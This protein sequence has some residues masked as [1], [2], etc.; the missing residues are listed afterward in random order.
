MAVTSRLFNAYLRRF[1]NCQDNRFRVMRG[2]PEKE[3]QWERFSTF[4]GAG[5]SFKLAKLPSSRWLRAYLWVRISQ[6]VWTKASDVEQTRP[7]SQKSQYS[8]PS[9]SFICTYLLVLLR[10]S[11]HVVVVVGVDRRLFR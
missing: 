11:T 4:V 3:D 7:I 1:L 6:R 5:G 8:S 9:Q 10:T 2:L